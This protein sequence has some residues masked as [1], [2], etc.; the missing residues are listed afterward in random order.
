MGSF[1]I[2]CIC[3][4]VLYTIWRWVKEDEAIVDKPS[5]E[6]RSSRVFSSKAPTHS[7]REYPMNVQW[8]HYV[9]ADGSKIDVYRHDG[10]G[11]WVKTS[12]THDS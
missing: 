1:L 9:E 12:S 8:H 5:C 4:A 11:Y 6:E 2:W 7:D 10:N 3:A